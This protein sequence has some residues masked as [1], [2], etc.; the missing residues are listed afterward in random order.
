[1]RSYASVQMVFGFFGKDGL[2]TEDVN[3]AVSHT[4]RKAA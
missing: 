3:S 1:M 4:D 2:L